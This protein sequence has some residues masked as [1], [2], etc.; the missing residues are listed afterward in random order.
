[1]KR[2][3]AAVQ[4]ERALA[5]TQASLRESEARFASALRATNDGVWE[6]LIPENRIY[7]SARWKAIL[8][9]QPDE[10]PDDYSEWQSRVHPGDRARFAKAREEFFAGSGS[11][12]SI[13]Y[14]LQHK[15]GAYRW[16][17]LRGFLQRSPQGK[18][19]RLT[20]ADADVTERKQLE[21]EILRISDREQWRIGQELHDGLG[22][23]LTAIELMCQSLKTDV[24]TE[25]P[26]L[27]GQLELMGKFLREAIAQTRS[28]AHGLTPF[29]LD[30]DGLQAAL[31]ELAQRTNSVG[32]MKCRFV[33]PAAVLLKDSEA[34]G[35]IFRI[36]QE[37][38]S[39]A[40]KHAGATEI[41]LSLTSEAGAVE[42]QVTDN[43]KGLPKVQ[44]RRDGM[45][46]QVMRH[47]A[48]AIGAE[49]TVESKAGR[50]VAVTCTLR[51][52][53]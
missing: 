48:N 34:A 6:W 52:T 26:E 39:N 13:E 24:D 25:R 47:R 11:L 45:G 18:P 43:G 8:G 29:M 9:Y 19:L 49:L 31:A 22:Q 20:G 32:R 23:Q 50:G 14:R 7:F 51:K 2:A 37:A 44:R 4:Q 42:L 16:I 40:L 46:L 27:S 1:V 53:S 35:H 28:L 10:I 21:K 30:A 38:V 3:L 12:F 15:D 41:V 36:A 33:C 5:A 17:L